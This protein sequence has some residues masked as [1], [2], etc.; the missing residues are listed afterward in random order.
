MAITS[1]PGAPGDTVPEPEPEPRP[2]VARRPTGV[3][4]AGVAAVV[5]VGAVAGLGVA[6]LTVGSRKRADEAAQLASSTSTSSPST[7]PGTVATSVAPATS[8]AP[9]SSAVDTS[10]PASSSTSVASSSTSASSTTLTPSTT[11]T[12]RTA[13]QST[14]PVTTAPSAPAAIQVAFSQ[15]QSGA[16]VVPRKG[17]AMIQLTNSG[18][19]EGQWLLRVNG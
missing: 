1:T 7:L 13:P 18:G 5:V 19:Q 15:D 8:G 6:D 2:S 12:P 17:T 16:L 3:L 11:Q 4:I 9:P 14:E 10:A